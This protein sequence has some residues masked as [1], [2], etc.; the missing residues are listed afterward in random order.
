MKLRA[1]GGRA[2]CALL[3]C[4]GWSLPGAGW[5]ATMQLVVND[6]AGEGF[7]DSTAVTPVGGNEG[8]TLGEQRR[9]ALQY[10]ADI[11][12]SRIG[13]PLPIR[14]VA[15]FESLDCDND[16]GATLARS[17]P[18]SFSANFGA[19]TAQDDV[20]YPV[21]L[22]NA[23][24]GR[25]IANVPNDIVV[26]FNSRLDEGN[27]GCLSGQRWYYGLDGATAP[28]RTSFVSTAVHELT[29]GLGF[30][31]LVRLQDTDDSRAGQ[32]P[33]AQSR[34]AR[35]PD[36]F[37]TFIQD[38][39]F[40]GNPRWPSLTDD[41]RRR[42][43]T[44]A[45]SVVWG[46]SLTNSRAM[47]LLSDGFSQGRLQMYAP[48][49]LRPG[50]S[51]SHWDVSLSPD[52][53]MEPFATGEDQVIRGIGISSCVLEN[54]GWQLIN[55]VRCPDVGGPAIAGAPDDTDRGDDTVNE[56]DP[57]PTGDTAI[58]SNDGN[59]RDDAGHGGGGCSV[60]RHAAFDPIW[61]M[62]LSMAALVIGA[63]GRRLRV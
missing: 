53:I 39:S 50:S 10:A 16:N 54:L 24:R 42:S 27:A 19:A 30:V 56:A 38:L 58:M 36:V 60:G 48:Q 5:A 22:A 3:L 20:F 44:N 62:L 18:A 52:Q 8:E 55:G 40:S 11:L 28:R 26:S 33:T 6:P 1:K 34:G 29:H 12:G 25:R 15:R 31:S 14:I 13:S 35:F 9:I 57:A 41:Q 32:F 46:D 47:S 21:A 2:L 43:L 49:Q 45:P 51:I 23:M 61:I 59:A 4:A 17:S 63:R 37:S 7:N